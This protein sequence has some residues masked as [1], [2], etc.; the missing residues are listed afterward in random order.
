MKFAQTA[1]K[2]LAVAF[3]LPKLDPEQIEKLKGSVGSNHLA[4]GVLAFTASGAQTTIEPTPL[5]IGGALDALTKQAFV[6]DIDV[7]TSYHPGE[8]PTV[9]LTLRLNAEKGQSDKL[10][11]EVHAW[12]AKVT[13]NW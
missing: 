8:Y 12:A 11:N 6:A 4:P 7:S 2:G 10:V 5:S 13:G 3:T 9:N 1:K